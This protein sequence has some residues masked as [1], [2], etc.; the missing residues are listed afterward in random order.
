ME[1]KFSKKQQRILNRR[2]QQQKNEGESGIE[3][4]EENQEEEE[5][6]KRKVILLEKKINQLETSNSEIKD[7]LQILIGLLSK[8]QEEE[9]NEREKQIE[10]ENQ[11]MDENEEINVNLEN[12]TK[13]E[14]GNEENHDDYDY[15][16]DVSNHSNHE[17]LTAI[18][19]AEALLNVRHTAPILSSLSFNAI[20]NFLKSY[21][22]YTMNITNPLFLKSVCDCIDDDLL[23]EIAEY[24]E[25]DVGYLKKL[26]ET[27]LEEFLFYK[28]KAT[29]VGDHTE[30]LKKHVRYDINKWPITAFVD[31]VRDWNITIKAL[32]KT[33]I[34]S[35]RQYIR[36]FLNGLPNGIADQ[37]RQL[38]LENL[39]D[40]KKRVREECE[41]QQEF[42]KQCERKR[43]DWRKEIRG[44]STASNTKS[45][46]Q[47]NN[48]QSITPKPNQPVQNVVIPK[49]NYCTMAG[50]ETS[51]CLIKKDDVAK[52]IILERNPKIS[53]R[54][55][56]RNRQFN[57]GGRVNGNASIITSSEQLMDNEMNKTDFSDGDDLQYCTKVLKKDPTTQR[58]NVPALVGE[59]G[60]TMLPISGLYDP[61]STSDFIRGDVI[62]ELRAK[63][64][65]I[66]VLKGGKAF[67][68]LAQNGL[69][70]EIEAKRAVI[71]V[72]LLVGDEPVECRMTPLV[73]DDAVAPIIFGLPMCQKY[74]L[75][76]YIQLDEEDVNIFGPFDKET[77]EEEVISKLESERSYFESE[78]VNLHHLNVK[79]LN[80]SEGVDL[81]EV[82]GK[83]DIAPSFRDNARLKCI[84][85]NH[86]PSLTA[87]LDEEGM[88]VPPMQ[89]YVKEGSDTFVSPYRYVSP[90]DRLK[91]KE[92]IDKLVN[93]GI[94][95]EVHD[96][97]YS[98]PLVLIRKK[99]GALRIAVDYRCLNEIVLPYAGSIPSM[100]ELFTFLAGKRFYAKFDNVAGFHQ[101][102]VD[103][104]SRKFTVITTPFG[105]FEWTRMPFG[106][107]TAPGIYQHRMENFVLKGLMGTAATCYI[108]DTLVVG[109]TED[110]FLSN[111]DMVLNAFKKFNVRLKVEKCSIGHSSIQFLGHR[112]DAD[113]YQLTEE[114]KQGIRDLAPPTSLTQ[115]RSFLG[116]VN[117][118]REFVPNLSEVLV[119]I[120][121][122]TKGAKGNRFVWT[123]E[124]DVAFNKVKDLIC[125]ATALHHLKDDGAIF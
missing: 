85:A 28:H 124:A 33:D 72:R 45:K 55:R 108:D 60:G 56:E 17:Q 10:E 110:E 30:K 25:R 63:G 24:H 51:A 100:K 69:N 99:D 48:T 53:R 84:L 20:K 102:K 91:L 64:V 92:D 8:R 13:N 115:L 96:A 97:V 79:E 32:G 3:E 11:K 5:M 120:T 107:K 12:I 87:P 93:I 122:L 7:Q 106:I 65:K 26:S 105:L 46:I 74:G 73:W 47:S 77:P 80:G 44:K 57:S 50:H 88:R 16:D 86:L 116:L 118:T 78:L 21:K 103:E 98:S 76:N 34:P 125:N 22:R 68:K 40:V 19:L 18:N 82:M 81:E 14:G 75:S 66:K 101:L 95:K 15:G 111:L 23:E 49:C 109:E 61:G 38:D 70:T 42:R 35:K 83:L 123:A 9:R 117:F 94:L 89:I 59:F 67:I 113:G 54:Q 121:D 90:S 114:R 37:I 31:Y 1:Q 39:E 43:F 62:E 4:E 27:E 58:I 41:K 29:T 6:E 2:E 36:I 119:P 52:G 104:A 112:F 71:D